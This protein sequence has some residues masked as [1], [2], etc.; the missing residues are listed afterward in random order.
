MRHSN[1]VFHPLLCSPFLRWQCISVGSS[2]RSS[3]DLIASNSIMAS[4]AMQPS[5]RLQ[6]A[7]CS[8]HQ[9]VH[10]CRSIARAATQAQPH[11]ARA[12]PNHPLA[13]S[14]PLATTELGAGPSN[15]PSSSSSPAWVLPS[16]LGGLNQ[17][18][19]L[20]VA[21]AAGVGVF[22]SGFELDGPG[23]VLEALA[24]LASIIAVHE[25]GH[26]T[27]ARLQGI[28]VTQFAIGFGPPLISFKVT[29]SNVLT[30]MQ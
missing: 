10:L 3:R 22:G 24:V 2:I 29:S 27:A 5:Q 4:T 25:W 21:A 6:Q 28:H 13:R 23:S 18:V 1:P 30:C 14:S 19:L 9:P 15:R 20:G 16:S 7:P 26:F 8:R 12:T 11:T 17:Q